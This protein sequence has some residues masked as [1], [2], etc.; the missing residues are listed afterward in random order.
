LRPTARSHTLRSSKKSPKLPN[1]AP[2]Q[3][4]APTPPTPLRTAQ[5]SGPERVPSLSRSSG[6]SR[7]V[8]PDCFRTC[9]QVLHPGATGHEF[10]RLNARLIFETDNSV[11]NTSGEKRST[12]IATSSAVRHVAEIG[13]AASSSVLCRGTRITASFSLTVEPPSL[14]RASSRND[15]TELSNLPTRDSDGRSSN[16]HDSPCTGEG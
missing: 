5:W 16:L 2:K 6:G 13:I 14:A 9:A 11:V 10:A 12:I 1:P 3:S 7:R 15:H 8:T 4:L